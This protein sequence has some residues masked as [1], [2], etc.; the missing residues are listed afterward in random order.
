MTDPKYQHGSPETGWMEQNDTPTRRGDGIG[1]QCRAHSFHE[2]G[3]P[4]ADWTPSEVYELKDQ[5]AASNAEVARLREL[6]SR[7]LECLKA[8]GGV[9]GIEAARQIFEELAPA[10]EEKCSDDTADA[11]DMECE[12]YKTSAHPDNCIGKWR[13]DVVPLSEKITQVSDKEGECRHG[14]L[15]G[16]CD[17]CE[18]AP[19][20]RELGP[21]EVICEGDEVQP[22]HH[23]KINGQWASV[24]AFEVGTPP[25]HHNWAR[26][27][28]IRPLPKHEEE[29]LLKVMEYCRKWA[30]EH[31][32][33]HGK[34]TFYARLGLLVDFATDLYSDEIEALK[35]NQK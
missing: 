16:W 32:A 34:E 14:F 13:E 6:L 8:Y 31:L 25:S 9:L 5:L 21:D 11:A 7:A 2:C 1:C 22:K 12:D 10:P 18:P 27:R 29:R 4:D 30:D 15:K 3:C 19:E 26:Y 17:A 33:D 20:W 24:F 35:K 23:D 28:T